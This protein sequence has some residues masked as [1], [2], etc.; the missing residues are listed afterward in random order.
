M[1]TRRSTSGYCPTPLSAGNEHELLA[2]AYMFMRAMME[3]AATAIGK[4]GPKVGT[5]NNHCFPR[6]L[7]SRPSDADIKQMKLMG[8]RMVAKARSI[9]FVGCMMTSGSRK[10]VIATAA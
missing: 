3:S 10:N 8:I 9:F 5:S 6:G 4:I 1:P 7:E 2:I